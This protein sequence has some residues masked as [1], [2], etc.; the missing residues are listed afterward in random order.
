MRLQR[1]TNARLGN[2]WQATRRREGLGTILAVVVISAL[3]I[4][5]LSYV[6]E[7]PAPTG[8]EPSTPPATYRAQ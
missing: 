4:A 1:N 5:G 3:I 8:V 7:P 6:I 2:V